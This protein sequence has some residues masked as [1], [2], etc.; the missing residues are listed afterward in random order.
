M[1]LSIKIILLLNWLCLLFPGEMTEDLCF[2]LQNLRMLPGK[3][4]DALERLE[5]GRTRNNG[6]SC[7]ITCLLRI[8]FVEQRGVVTLM[9]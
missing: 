9:M 3:D 6:N 4:K 7:Y 5:V 8:R 1:V 2:T